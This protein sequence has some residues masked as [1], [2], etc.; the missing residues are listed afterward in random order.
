LKLP[1]DVFEGVREV[2]LVFNPQGGR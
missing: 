2:E 1:T